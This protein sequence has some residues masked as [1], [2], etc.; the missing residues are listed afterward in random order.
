MREAAVVSLRAI[1]GQNFRYDP[2]ANETE[3]SRRIKAWRDW[4][5]KV[6]DELLG[7]DG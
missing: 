4:W 3:R 7:G 1:S 2:T 5:N 6:S